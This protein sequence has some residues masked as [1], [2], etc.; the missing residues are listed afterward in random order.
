MLYLFDLDDTLISGYMNA[1]DKNYNTWEVLPGRLARLDDLRERGHA[2]GI[3]TNQAGV[4]WGYISESDVRY[5][6]NQVATVLGFNG[7]MIHDGGV[8]H[9]TGSRMSRT[10]EL[11]AWVCYDD[12]RAPDK[13]YKLDSRRKPSGAMI[14]EAAAECGYSLVVPEVLYVGDRPEDE[15]AAKDAGCNFQWAHIFFKD[16][17]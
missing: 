11:Y 5:K 13:R 16:K 15:T 1:A 9:S 10:E 17:A 8:A 3:V 14:R 4:A 6:L 2:I 7:V 12:K